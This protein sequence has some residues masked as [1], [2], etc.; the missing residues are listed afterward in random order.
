[1]MS[2]AMKEAERAVKKSQNKN[3]PTVLGPIFASLK[4]NKNADSMSSNGFKY[5]SCRKSVTGGYI[6]TFI[7]GVTLGVIN[8]LI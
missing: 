7:F 6:E 8:L 1:M 3:R 4:V 2:G 5:L